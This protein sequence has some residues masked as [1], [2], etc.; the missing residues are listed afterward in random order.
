VSNVL[1]CDFLQFYIVFSDYKL[2]KSRNFRSLRHK[3]DQNYSIL[4]FFS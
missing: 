2:A 4:Y 3:K 1:M